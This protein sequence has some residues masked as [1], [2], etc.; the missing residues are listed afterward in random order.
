MKWNGRNGFIILLASS[1][2]ALQCMGCMQIIARGV[3]TSSPEKAYYGQDLPD[4]ETAVVKSFYP[5]IHP[6]WN[7]KSKIGIVS[8]DGIRVRQHSFSDTTGYGVNFPVASIVRV[9]E[10][11]HKFILYAWKD[12]DKALRLISFRTEKGHEYEINAYA[13]ESGWTI[14][15]VM[16]LSIGKT[17]HEMKEPNVVG[18]AY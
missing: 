8:V 2:L 16:D 5:V 15:R 17:V 1:F 12:P 6:K 3:E 4:K 13:S 10:G 9:P 18:K 11:D 7:E 14:I